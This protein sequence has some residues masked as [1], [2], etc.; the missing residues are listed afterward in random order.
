MRDVGKSVKRKSDIGIL[1]KISLL[2]KIIVIL[3]VLIV[4]AEVEEILFFGHN[5]ILI[6]TISAI[7]GIAIILGIIVYSLLKH[8][9]ISLILQQRN[10][11]YGNNR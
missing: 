9:R 3:L 6:L 4:L 11:F 7:M 8:V 5:I 10:K 2:F 1:V